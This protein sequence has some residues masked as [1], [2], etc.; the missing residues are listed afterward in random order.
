MTKSISSILAILLFIGSQFNLNAVEI[1]NLRTE[2]KRN[3][4]GIDVKKPR[5][6]WQLVSD[7][8]GSYQSAFEIRCAHEAKALRSKKGLIWATGKIASSKSTHIEY[9]GTDLQ[10]GER[11]F[12]QVRVWDQKGK[13][14]KWSEPA[15]WEMGLLNSEDWKAKWIRPNDPGNKSQNKGMSP[16]FRKEIVVEKKIKDARVYVSSYGLYELHINGTKVSEDLLTPGFTNYEKRLQYQVY[17]VS[18]MLEPSKN[19]VAAILGNGWYKDFRDSNKGKSLALIMQL[20]IEYTD[21]TSEII[22]TDQSWKSAF[23]AIRYS[24]IYNGETYDATKELGNWNE[25][26]NTTG[27]WKPVEL[28]DG[29]MEMLASINEPVQIHER[30]KPVSIQKTDDDKYIVDFGQNLVGFISISLNGKGFEGNKITLRHTEVLDKDGG[31]YIESLRAAKQTNQYIIKGEEQE[32]YTPRFT[33]QGFQYAEITGFPGELTADNLEALVVHS[34]LER[35]GSF[36]CSDSSINQLFKNV[37]WGQKGNFVDVPTDCPQ[38]DERLGWTGDT[39]VFGSTGCF[40][41][42]S[43]TFY[44]KWLK[45]L[46]ADQKADGSVPDVVPDVLGHGGRAGWADAAVVVPWTLYEFYGDVKVLQEQYESMAKYIA[47][48]KNRAGD[49][50]L[51]QGDF[52]YGDWLSFNTTRSDYPGAYTDRDLIATAYFAYSTSLMAKIAKIIGKTEDHQNYS[53]LFQKIREAFQNEYLTTAG[54]LMSN[55]QT[56]YTLALQFDLIPE[57]QKDQAALY[58]AERVNHFNHITTGFL[59]TP[60][61]SFALSENGYYEEAYKL[62][63]RKEFPGWLYPVTKGATTIWERWDGIKPDGS[64][65]DKG[66][67]SFNHYAYGAIAN[68]M[69]QVI[70]G[71][72]I[73]ESNAGFKTVIIEPHP[74]GEITWANTSYN[75]IHGMIESKWEEDGSALSLDVTIPANCSGIIRILADSGDKIFIDNELIEFAKLNFKDEKSFKGFELDLASGTYNLRRER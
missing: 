26:G 46:A 41:M 5:L 44:T 52:H 61:I 72:Q 14:S 40:N 38:R 60:I 11:V 65:Q 3:P 59:G 55:T 68:W 64:F 58:L 70:G 66:M 27:D 62:L 67:N 4:I 29:S 21:G 25:A 19:V 30:L 10:S 32:I 50:Y 49:N 47:F 20:E 24:S 53:N 31:F 69:Y 33:F 51:W 36:E 35:T 15:F 39:Q 6:F 48:M 23:G 73:S 17:D 37:I 22:I 16:Y 56:A 34:A 45:D 43:S 28:Y 18:T 75:S 1:I 9:G 74:G 57:H 12:W 42:L 8:N 63:L 71:I 54:R 2:Y 7:Q 13:A